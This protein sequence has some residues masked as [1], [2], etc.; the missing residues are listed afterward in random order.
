MAI[1][2]WR[3]LGLTVAIWI[4]VAEELPRFPDWASRHFGGTFST[5]FFIVSHATTLLPAITAAGLMPARNPRSELGNW[6]ATSTAAGML[7]NA[8]FHAA[9][10]LRWREYSP[11]VISAVTLI[12]P[13]ATQ[14]LMLT[15]EAGIKGK[16]RGASNRRQLR[17][18]RQYRRHG[19]PRLS[20][21][22]DS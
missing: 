6:L 11:G 22:G 13:T 5:R 1:R 18:L 10:T 17:I 21:S 8:I 9:T 7:A 20:H 16:R 4:H 14:T 3:Y 19:A 15:K 12:G 2:N